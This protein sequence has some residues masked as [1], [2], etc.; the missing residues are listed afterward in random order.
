MSASAIAL[1]NREG[2]EDSPTDNPGV[3]GGNGGNGTDGD[4]VDRG[5]AVSSLA[6][7]GDNVNVAVFV[8]LLMVSAAAL[9]AAVCRLRKR[10]NG[11]SEYE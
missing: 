5:D 9:A 6:D 7:T 8:R 1:V 3:D 2:S 11:A 10:G 4:S